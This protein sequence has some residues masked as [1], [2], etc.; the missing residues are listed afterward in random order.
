[1]RMQSTMRH[2]IVSAIE[3]IFADTL[4]SSIKGITQNVYLLFSLPVIYVRH[5]HGTR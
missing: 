1:M 3:A 4:G 5:N 2:A